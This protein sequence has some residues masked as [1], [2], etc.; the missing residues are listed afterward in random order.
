MTTPMLLGRGY[1]VMKGVVGL[2][3]VLGELSINKWREQRFLLM[4]EILTNKEYAK[5]F[6]DVF[7]NEGRYVQE[8]SFNY[9]IKKTI[10][11][12]ALAQS[13]A[14]VSEI[15]RRANFEDEEIYTDYKDEEFYIRKPRLN[16]MYERYGKD[17]QRV[18]TRIFN[19]VSDEFLDYLTLKGRRVVKETDK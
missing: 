11:L 2:R 9:F 4:K 14:E 17:T 5:S 12:N 19:Q 7:S 1:N 15:D 8:K 10:Q 6:L 16:I 18:N 13:R 3:Y